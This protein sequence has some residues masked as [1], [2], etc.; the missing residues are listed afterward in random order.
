[1]IK[2]KSKFFSKFLEKSDFSKNILSLQIS[3]D[4]FS[5]VV[6]DTVSQKYVAFFSQGFDN[7]KGNPDILLNQLK[8]EFENNLLLQKSF[9]KM[10][11][12]HWN[13]W[14]TV[15]PYAFFDK[16][17]L[18]VY[19]KYS[20]KTFAEDF[21][22][23]DTLETS[24]DKVVYVPFVNVNNYL[25]NH[26]GTFDYYHIGTKLIQQISHLFP[27]ECIL[28]IHVCNK[29]MVMV[30]FDKTLQFYNSFSF[31]TPEDFLYYILFVL[32]Q[33][34]V[35]LE[36]SVLI[37]GDIAASDDIYKICK[38]YLK[39]VQIGTYQNNHIASDLKNIP[40]QNYIS[41]LK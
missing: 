5:F 40:V 29:K 33:I 27:K 25:F 41:L 11:V 7:E 10:E 16:R 6:F 14:A 8:T 32:E 9:S 22:A 31:E 1:M 3:L 35:D 24:Q 21:I 4:G 39:N 15:V 19:L 26:F 30:H 18:E 37:Y 23:Y 13:Q 36:L 20:T 12:I 2:R 38:A 28:Y 17:Y 34:P